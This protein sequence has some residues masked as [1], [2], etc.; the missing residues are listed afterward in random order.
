MRSTSIRYVD[1]EKSVVA[2]EV[3]SWDRDDIPAPIMSASSGPKD[4]FKNHIYQEFLDR[5]EIMRITLCTI[6][7]TGQPFAIFRDQQNCWFDASGKQVIAEW[8]EPKR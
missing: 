1:G 7:R 2:L 8:Q 4:Y 3:F 6:A 5:P